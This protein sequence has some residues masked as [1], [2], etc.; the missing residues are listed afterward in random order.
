MLSSIQHPYPISNTFQSLSFNN[1][2]QFHQ[3][4]FLNLCTSIKRPQSSKGEVSRIIPTK[5]LELEIRQ[6]NE[7]NKKWE[8]GN[9][10]VPYMDTKGRLSKWNVSVDDSNFVYNKSKLGTDSFHTS[11]Y[12]PNRV[13]SNQNIYGMNKKEAKVPEK[14]QQ[15]H[16]IEHSKIDIEPPI[17]E[18]TSPS[19]SLKRMIITKDD[20][21]KENEDPNPFENYTC[22]N[23]NN[24][25]LYNNSNDSG[26]NSPV[27]MIYNTEFK[28]PARNK[29]H[30]NHPKLQLS[31]ERISYTKK[32]T[33]NILQNSNLKIMDIDHINNDIIDNCETDVPMVARV[34]N[35]NFINSTHRMNNI[36][37]NKRV[38]L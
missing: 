3:N 38:R 7:A 26:K 24:V 36:T 32:S 34:A 15:S 4:H 35:N 31:C 37:Y 30:A 20:S 5:Y 11:S 21:N 23:I 13:N 6:F 2:D 19:G 10:R 14:N 27:L 25:I 29:Y 8:I 12:L 28:S 17:C 1:A 16:D 33:S 18:N 22:N 9:K